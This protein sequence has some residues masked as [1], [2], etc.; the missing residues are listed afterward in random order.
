[1]EWALVRALRGALRG[2]S[3]DSGRA[4][5]ERLGALAGV[6]GIRKRVALENLAIAFPG[7]TEVEHAAILREHYREL[8][9]V[10]SEYARLGDLARSTPIPA[11]AETR[12]LEHLERALAGGKGA[13]VMSGHFSNFELMAAWAAQSLPM[14]LVVRPLRNPQVEAWL[15][16]ER[17]RA[18]FG[19]ISADRGVR[20][21]FESL[22]ANRLVA[23]LADQDARRHGAFVPFFGRPSS[24]AIGPARIA[25]QTGAPLVTGYAT[26]RPDGRMDIDVEGPLALERPDAD[27]AALRLTALHTRHLEARVRAAPAMWFWLHRRWKTSPPTAAAGGD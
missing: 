19:L 18:G 21:V 17:L 7:K 26:R 14:D 5:G 15:R 16:D 4:A 27:D 12:G 11:F 13:I 22:R 25:L 24:T 20:G 8:G 9:R 2:R 3:W 23:M 6:L 10:V 1:M